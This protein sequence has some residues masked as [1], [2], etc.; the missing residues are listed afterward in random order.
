MTRRKNL[1]QDHWGIKNGGISS[2]KK[3]LL[4]NTLNN[5][6]FVSGKHKVI[7]EEFKSGTT[8]QM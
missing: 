4:S 8:K 2:K 6:E 7:F 3:K 1:F 5:D